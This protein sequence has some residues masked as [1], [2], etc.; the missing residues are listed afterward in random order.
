[1][2]A[3]ERLLSAYPKIYFACHVRH[4]RDADTG[5]QISAH[6]ASI[7]DHL[8]EVEPQSLRELARH[9]GVSDSTMSLTLD[10]LV[11]DG[12]VVRVRSENDARRLHLRL[13][14]AGVAIKRQQKVLDPRLVAALLSRLDPEDRDRAL[15]GLDLL[16]QA[17]VE[18]IQ[19]KRTTQ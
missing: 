18:L 15:A 7:L 16:A 9:M 3:V 4:V 8:D 17:A 13:T 1:M 12:Y 10:K 6:R 11:R 2:N 19:S 5:R 14:P